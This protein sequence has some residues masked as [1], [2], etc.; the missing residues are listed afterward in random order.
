MVMSA[1]VHSKKEVATPN[2][3]GKSLY[4]ALEELSSEGLGLKK[5]GEETDQNVPA[6]TILRQNPVG[7][8]TVREGKIVKVT[9]SQG[10]EMIYAPNLVGQ[11]I[12]SANIALRHSTL[13]MGEV[14]RKFS[15]VADKDIVISQDIAA[16]SKVDKDSVVNIDVTDGIPTEGI[17]LMP[18]FINKNIEEAKTWARQHDII[19]NVTT[20]E[21]SGVATGTVIKQYPDADVDITGAKSINLNVA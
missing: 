6:G 21:N 5:E 17:V 18:D 8:M 10:G 1:L 19:L 4:D 2:V 3:V 12:R 11:T 15:V 9:I 13:V 7:G 20:E 16:G 14:L